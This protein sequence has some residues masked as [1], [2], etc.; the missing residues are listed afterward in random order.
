MIEA[1]FELMS[2]IDQIATLVKHDLSLATHF[3][4]RHC[5]LMWTSNIAFG[6][7]HILP[8]LAK[9]IGLHF[10]TGCGLWVVF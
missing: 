4:P 2:Y 5:F 7:I 6:Q 8:C 10:L 9:A 3:E 1:F